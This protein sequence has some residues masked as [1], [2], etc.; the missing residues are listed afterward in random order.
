MSSSRHAH[1][2]TLLEVLVALVIFATV[3]GGLLSTVSQAVRAL[4][5]AESEVQVM[6]LAQERIRELQRE[7]ESGV[8]P[9]L[10][11]SEGAFPEPWDHLRWKLSVRYFAFPTP[12]GLSFEQLRD[13]RERSAMFAGAPGQPT[14]LRLVVLRVLDD[15]GEELLDPFSIVT[16]DSASETARVPR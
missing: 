5:S 3:M 12:E 15:A 9:D 16:A 4:G 14:S 6:E 1:G 10:G 11:E 7:A 8:Q 13:M 2:F